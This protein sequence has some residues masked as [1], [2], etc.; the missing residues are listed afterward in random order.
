[1]IKCVK[2]SGRPAKRS[3]Q[4]TRTGRA[5]LRRPDRAGRLGRLA[6]LNNNINRMCHK[7][8]LKPSCNSS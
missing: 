6:P 3:G 2:G 4:S 7:T 8:T 1:M 5:S